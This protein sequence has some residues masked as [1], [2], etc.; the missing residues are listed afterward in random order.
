MKQYRPV[1]ATLL[2]CTFS[3]TAC[4]D[5]HTRPLEI[6]SRPIPFAT[7]DDAPQS[8]G[9]LQHL[10]S[11]RLTSPDPNFGGIS[12]LIVAPDGRKFLAITDASHWLTGELQYTGKR[13]TGMTGTEIGPLLDLDGKALVGK[14]GDAEGLAGTLDGDVYVSFEGNHR[15]WRY[16]FGT[17][18]LAAKPSLV[19][20]PKDLQNAPD[21]NGLEAITLLKD[22]RLLAIT[23]EYLDDNGNIK[24]WLLSLN[25]QSPVDLLFR[26]R[27]PFDITDARQLPDGDILTL[28][29]R[30]NRVGG[31]GFEMRR[32]AQASL[33]PGAPIDGALVADAAMNFNIDNMEGLSVRTGAGGE[34]LVY[35]ISDDNF[36][37]PLQQNLLMLFELKR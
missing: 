22:G 1:L 10:G 28:E 19:P 11:L 29:R 31:V 3:M 34:T 8:V 2:L 24:G 9:N 25:G 12:G 35:A 30:F 7:G 17:K 6:M 26:R 33:K 20:T 21:N 18:G 15:L 36:N 13:L 37:A 27:A 4:A 23:E 16:P 5:E 32:F 14:Q